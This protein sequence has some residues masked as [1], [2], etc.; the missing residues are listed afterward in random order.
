[1]PI[2]RSKV[3][4]T[5][6]S[7]FKIVQNH[8]KLPDFRPRILRIARFTEKKTVQPCSELAVLSILISV[9]RILFR[10][11]IFELRIFGPAW[12][13]FSIKTSPAQGKNQKSQNFFNSFVRK[14]LGIP[15]DAKICEKLAQTRTFVQ[16]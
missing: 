4:Q 5:D 12:P 14:Q 1:L 10:I 3:A 16:L 13:K 2:F 9:I 11:S 6:R 8:S 15:E 7:S